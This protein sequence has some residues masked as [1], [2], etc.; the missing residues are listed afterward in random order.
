QQIHPDFLSRLQSSFSISSG[1]N[2]G[3]FS[4]PVINGQMLYRTVD[5]NIVF[6]PQG[7]QDYFFSR[8]LNMALGAEGAQRGF[9][10]VN[11]ATVR[12]VRTPNFELSPGVFRNICDFEY[13]TLFAFYPSRRDTACVL[14]TQL[15]APTNP[16]QVF[17]L[18]VTPFQWLYNFDNSGSPRTFYF[19][20]H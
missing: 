16:P 9:Q 18:W 2:S 7:Y 19:D 4:A 10:Q 3:P 13:I 6:A 15:V 8:L 5:Y 17:D 1:T 14:S 20:P 11:P 12:V